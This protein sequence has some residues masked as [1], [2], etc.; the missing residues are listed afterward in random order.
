LEASEVSPQHWHAQEPLANSAEGA[1]W[2]GPADKQAQTD[3]GNAATIDMAAAT[4]T[5]PTLTQ[6]LRRAI[7]IK[8]TSVGIMAHR[9]SFDNA[10]HERISRCI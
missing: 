8:L 6:P 1:V 7:D 2:L 5:N 9:T 4:Q 10:G 3:P